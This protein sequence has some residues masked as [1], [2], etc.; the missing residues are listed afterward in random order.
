MVEGKREQ[1]FPFFFL[2]RKSSKREGRWKGKGRVKGKG[3]PRTREDVSGRFT[4]WVPTVS[5]VGP[6]KR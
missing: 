4:S 2:E 1:C 3:Q 5:T 6:S